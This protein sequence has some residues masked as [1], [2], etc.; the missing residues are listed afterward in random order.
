MRSV[1]WGG[2]VVVG[3]VEAGDVEGGMA[4]GCGGALR[5]L[6]VVRVFR[7]VVFRWGSSEVCGPFVG[8]VGVVVVCQGLG[9][10]EGGDPD[11]L[12]V[13]LL[14]SPPENKVHDD[15]EEAFPWDG[16]VRRGLEDDFGPTFLQAVPAQGGVQGPA[17]EGCVEEVGV[18]DGGWREGRASGVRR[19]LAGWAAEV[20]R[21]YVDVGVVFGGC[22]W[23]GQCQMVSRA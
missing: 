4:V 11:A 16:E 12:V 18:A 20:W 8:G 17:L 13:R 3:G 7:V 22:C 19:G 2:E 10:L 15:L 21:V 6:W 5:L 9:P 14:L 23:S 1:G